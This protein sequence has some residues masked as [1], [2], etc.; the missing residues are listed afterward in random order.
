MT[1]CTMSKRSYHGA[2]SRSQNK[3]RQMTAR[4]GCIVHTFTDK[5][6]MVT[7]IFAIT[8]LDNNCELLREMSSK[9]GFT[10]F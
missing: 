5:K 4:N 2:T 1:H 6:G 3:M 8:T 7:V 9:V 10:I